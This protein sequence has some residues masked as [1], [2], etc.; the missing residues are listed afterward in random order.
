M[1]NFFLDKQPAYPGGAGAVNRYHVV[2]GV[3]IL[4]LAEDPPTDNVE[5]ETYSPVVIL[6]LHA[7]YRLR[8]VIYDTHK[9]LN[10]P[11]VPSPDDTGAFIY[12]SGSILFTPR[13]TTGLGTLKWDVFSDY[14]Y[15]ENCVHRIED[16]FVIGSPPYEDSI[17]EQNISGYGYGPVPTIGAISQAGLDALN[18][19][20]MENVLIVP[21]RASGAWVYNAE[22]FFPGSLFSDAMVNGGLPPGG[23]P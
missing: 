13:N 2:P 1:S 21:N 3:C 11:F 12:S 6:R 22:A 14:T 17:A 5:L 19:R 23:G 10:P 20:V 16:G 18:G 8:R 7:P 9:S 4:P 15:V